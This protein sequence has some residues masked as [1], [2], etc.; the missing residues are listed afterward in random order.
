MIKDIVEN[1]LNNEYEVP[2]EDSPWTDGDPTTG[3]IIEQ[4]V[5]TATIYNRGVYFIRDPYVASQKIEGVSLGDRYLLF[6]AVSFFIKGQKIYINRKVTYNQIP[7]FQDVG[8]KRVYAYAEVLTDEITGKLKTEIKFT[9]TFP[10]HAGNDFDNNDPNFIDPQYN[11]WFVENKENIVVLGCYHITTG[12]NS[13]PVLNKF[14]SYAR[15][16]EVSGV[17]YG[18]TEDLENILIRYSL[19][20][21]GRYEDPL[22]V[23]K[24]YSDTPRV[25]VNLD[26]PIP[27]GKRYDVY[28]SVRSFEGSNFTSERIY[29][30][31]KNLTFFEIFTDSFCDVIKVDWRLNIVDDDREDGSTDTLN[32]TQ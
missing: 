17:P 26:S 29:I 24:L 16:E 32:I 1:Y 30:S 31:N 6:P 23:T 21:L 5:G 22:N 12:D 7:K 15:L 27:S 19:G 11:Q 14:Y 18:G 9:P 3:E 25:L 13:S 8:E 10:H 2:W 20:D 4:R 28:I